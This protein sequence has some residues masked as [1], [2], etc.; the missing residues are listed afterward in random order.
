MTSPHPGLRAVAMT[1]DCFSCGA[2]DAECEATP[3]ASCCPG[4]VHPGEVSRYLTDEEF[5]ALA[6]AKDE[7]WC[8]Q[9]F[10]PPCTQDTPHLYCA[11]YYG[12]DTPIPV[13]SGKPSLLRAGAIRLSDRRRKLSCISAMPAPYSLDE[14]SEAMNALRWAVGMNVFTW[15]MEATR[16][17]QIDAMIRAADHLEARL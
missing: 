7:P 2:A 1:G 15:S 3:E 16:D 13:A 12:F 9:R 4:C 5:N 11:A 10:G 6:D 8:Q 14:F 17:E